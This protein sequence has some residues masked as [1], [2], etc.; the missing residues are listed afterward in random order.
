MHIHLGLCVDGRQQHV[1]AGIPQLALGKGQRLAQLFAGVPLRQQVD[2][3]QLEGAVELGQHAR[4]AQFLDGHQRVYRLQQ[5]VLV[6]QR[7]FVVL[8]RSQISDLAH[9]LQ[10]HEALLCVAGVNGRHVGR[11]GKQLAYADEAV[12][13]LVLGRGIHHDAG[14][15]VGQGGAEVSAE[16]GVGRGKLYRHVLAGKLR[17]QPRLQ[18]F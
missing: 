2:F 13:I 4:L 9:I 10:Q 5:Q 17:G 15:A 12:G 18:G 11:R 16:I 8:Q 1:D 7:A 6:H 14:A 3:A